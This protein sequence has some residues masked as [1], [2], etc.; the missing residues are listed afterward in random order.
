MRLMINFS[1]SNFTRLMLNMNAYF[2]FE[3]KRKDTSL[4]ITRPKY[5]YPN[6]V[7]GN[8]K[9]QRHLLYPLHSCHKSCGLFSVRAESSSLSLVMLLVLGNS[10]LEYS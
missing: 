10:G 7:Q 8:D 3:G 5:A 2:K 6:F 9:F 1:I 4:V